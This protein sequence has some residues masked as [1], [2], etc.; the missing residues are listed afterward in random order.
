MVLTDAQAKARQEERECARNLVEKFGTTATGT[1]PDKRVHKL[2]PAAATEEDLA[3]LEKSVRR[4]ACAS[5]FKYRKRHTWLYVVGCVVSLFA[6]VEFILLMVGG[7]LGMNHESSSVWLIFSGMNV[8]TWFMLWR[9]AM[10]ICPNCRENIRTCSAECCHVCG[11]PLSH[12][13]CV[14]CGVDNSWIGWFRPYSNGSSRWI[15][16]CPGCGVEL[17]THIPRWRVD[18]V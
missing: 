16:Y 18:D 6:S 5:E 7:R 2:I 12:K 1:S 15:K 13:R 11:K 10:P 14:D 4:M 8:L 3:A 17:D 9:R